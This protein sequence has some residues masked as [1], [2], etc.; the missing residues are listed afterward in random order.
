M[1]G[2]RNING[3]QIKNAAKTTQSLAVGKGEQVMFEY[4]NLML[5]AMEEFYAEFWKRD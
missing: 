1:L 5:D 3:R 2:K 4:L